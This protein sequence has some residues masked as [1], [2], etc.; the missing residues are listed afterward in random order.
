MMSYLDIVEK[1]ILKDEVWKNTESNLGNWVKVLWGANNVQEHH[2]CW[3]VTDY[4]KR[5][6][7]SRFI[8]LNLVI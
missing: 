7:M 3:S 5:C 6:D 1:G 2:I 4:K 8:A